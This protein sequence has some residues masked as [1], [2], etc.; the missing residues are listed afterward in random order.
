MAA[1]YGRRTRFR[2]RGTYRRRGSVRG[3]LSRIKRKVGRYS[4][5]AQT[6]RTGGW[7]RLN[8]GK[9]ERKYLDIVVGTTAAPT[10]VDENGT[11]LGSVVGCAQGFTV[12]T[13]V[14]NKITVKSMEWCITANWHAL[15]SA[16]NVGQG[17]DMKFVIDT[18]AN[19]TAATSAM[20][21]NSVGFPTPL[22]LENRRRFIVVKHKNMLFPCNISV[23]GGTITMVSGPNSTLWKGYKRMNLDVIYADA[24]AT[25]AS[26]TT[27][28]LGFIAQSSAVAGAPQIYVRGYVRIRYTDA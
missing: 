20:I 23:G 4:R 22:N 11:G 16:E 13:R 1:R 14:G 25:F 6:L 21:N 18:Q 24:G 7:G 26:I 12:S 3:L 9:A 8:P 5:L 15:N 10:V 28:N 17:L 19:K 2:R 27:N